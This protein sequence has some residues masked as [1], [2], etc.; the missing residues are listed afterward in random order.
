ML[1]GSSEKTSGPD[2]YARGYPSAV[3]EVTKRCV[4][5]L[6]MAFVVQVIFQPSYILEIVLINVAGLT[7][8]Q[9]DTYHTV[10][11]IAFGVLAY[12]YTKRKVASMSTAAQEGDSQITPAN[13]GTGLEQPLLTN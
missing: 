5:C 12:L 8:Q 1:L 9:Y 3:W 4:V 2:S 6:G 7:Q 10:I 11:I 13:T